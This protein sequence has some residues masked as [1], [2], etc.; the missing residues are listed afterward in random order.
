MAAPRRYGAVPAFSAPKRRR[1]TPISSAAH[2]AGLAMALYAVAALVPDVAERGVANLVKA[3]DDDD[4]NDF[5]QKKLISLKLQSVVIIATA[6][7]G[8]R[9]FKV[10]LL[11]ARRVERP[12][13]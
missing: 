7:G 6:Q 5:S 10:Q 9:P 3:Q 4:P 8:T 1:K 2:V 13:S 12:C 11:R